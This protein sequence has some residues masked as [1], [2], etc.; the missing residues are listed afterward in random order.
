[1]VQ[2]DPLDV[3]GEEGEK[4]EGEE[5][6]QEEPQEEEEENPDGVPKFKPEEYK[7]TSYD[8]VP[9]NYV[10]VLKRL[11]MYPVTK[12]ESTLDH[13]G[14]DVEKILIEHLDNFNKRHENHYKGIIEIVKMSA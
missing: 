9:R 10:Q 8:G 7:W 5:E 11:K 3:D 4:Q 1:M 13:I 12:T 14:E 2:K 6:P